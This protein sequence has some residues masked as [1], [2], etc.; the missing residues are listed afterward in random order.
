[1]D[2]VERLR[3]VPLFARLSVDDLTRLADIAAEHTV[4]SGVPLVHQS[5]LGSR[6]FIIDR[7]EAIIHRVDDKGLRQT[8]GTLHAGDYFGATSLFLGE[9]RDATITALT[10]MH[11]WTISRT[12]FQELLDA[13][14]SIRHRLNVPDEIIA[15]LRAP[16]YTWLNPGE[17]VVHHTRRHWFVFLRPIFRATL[18]TAAYF[19][20]IAWLVRGGQI[21]LNFPVRVLPVLAIYVPFL[22]WHWFDWRN[23]YFVVTTQR[24][25]HQERIAFIY[26]SREQALVDRVQNVKITIKAE[27]ALLGYGDLAITTAADQGTVRFTDIPQPEKMRDL[28]MAQVVRASAIRHAAERDLI[29]A[30]LVTH[31]R[32]QSAGPNPL[33]E[34]KSTVQPVGQIVPPERPES[35]PSTLARVMS[36][37]GELGVFPW[38]RRETADSITWRKHWLF[39]LQ[40]ALLPLILTIIGITLTAASFLGWPPQLLA[41]LPALPFIALLGTAAAMGWLWWEFTDWGNDVYIVTDDRIIDV[42]KRPW[43]FEEHRRDASLGNIQNVSFKIPNFIASALN[44]GN[45][46]A[47]TAGAG[48]F[49]FDHVP[50]PSEVQR[51]IFRRMSAFKE[52]Q[53]QKDAASRRAEIAAWFSIY[54]ELEGSA[55][56]GVAALRPDGDWRFFCTKDGLVNET[57]R[58]IAIGP[59]GAI[60]FAT[61]EGVG[62]L[63]QS[64]GQDKWEAFTR[65]DGLISDDVRSVTIAPDGSAWFGTSNG[66]SRLNAQGQWDSFAAPDVL[67]GA[68]VSTIAIGPDQSVW[69]GTDQG[70]ARLAANGSWLYFDSSV[71]MVHDHVNSIL[72]TA[73]GVVWFGTR[74]GVSRLTPDSMWRTYTRANGLAADTVLSVALAPDGS[75]W[76]GTTF[77]ASRLAL[78]GSWESLTTRDG[79]A[80]NYVW[81]IALAPDGALWFGTDEGASRLTPDGAWRDYRVQDGLPDKEVRAIAAAPDGIIWFG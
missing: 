60:W 40:D 23:D 73:D 17:F 48:E 69:F 42:E 68:L 66:A 31:M 38:M 34:E 75:I 4:R 54:R 59:D 55:P 27:G 57:V 25:T 36:K 72:V 52:K 51:E 14:P 64:N 5:N 61:A 26:E 37:I 56:G 80:G 32:L 39:L 24:V 8:V 15:K 45:V 30:D 9:P 33:E 13:Y 1:M 28:I 76:F 20:F 22:I 58:A 19:L 65:S 43:F 7:G 11:I 53:R 21:E 62:K 46:I 67:P 10:E 78:D 35:G 3:Q 47:Q 71:G 79:L 81:V 50:Y 18:L 77:G 29:R 44:Y 70:A 2:L 49:T 41:T 6:F 63:T 74:G 12:D 16:R